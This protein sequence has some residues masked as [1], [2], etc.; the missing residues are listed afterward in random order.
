V[1]CCQ[2]ADPHDQPWG[3]HPSP[4]R[5]RTPEDVG[6]AGAWQHRGR[7]SSEQWQRF[8]AALQCLRGSKPAAFDLLLPF[9]NSV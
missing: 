9:T 6:R 7:F 5:A 1:L 4:A 2:F 3:R 8:Q